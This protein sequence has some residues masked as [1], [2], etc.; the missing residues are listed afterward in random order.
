MDPR[1]R[2]AEIQGF[3]RFL[4]VRLILRE[5]AWRLDGADLIEVEIEDRLQGLAGGGVAQ[6]FRQR[7]E[8]LGVLA[9]QGDEFGNG[10]VPALRA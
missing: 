1:G 4:T 8:P 9:L 5:A 10:V 2:A 6:R 7:L 3:L